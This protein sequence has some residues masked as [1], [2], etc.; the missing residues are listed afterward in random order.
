M[1]NGGT[2]GAAIAAALDSCTDRTPAGGQGEGVEYVSPGMKGQYTDE[3]ILGAEYEVL[4]D[5]KLGINYIHRSLPQVIEDISTDGGTN[6]LITNPG[7]DFASAS[8]DLAKQSA[9]ELMASG[10]TSLT[11]TGTN[12]NADKQALAALYQSRSDQLKSVGKFDKPSRNYD[13][14]AISATQR[15]TKRS[16]VIA[17]YTYSIEKG[18]YPGLFSTETGQLDPNLT[19][20]YDLPDLMANRY[21][22]LG[23]DRPHNLKIDGFYQF[24]LKDLGLLTAGGSVRA[25][26][27]IAHNVLGA[28]PHPGYGTGE[29][30]LLPRGVQDRSPLTSQFDVH[31]SYGRRLNKTVTIEAFANIFNLFDQQEQLN[32]DESYTFDGVNPVVGG[33]LN[34]LKH[35]KTLDISTQT[36]RE[37]NLTPV[38]NK[39]YG[40]T[41][42]SNGGP[43]LQ[44][45]RNIQF[46]MR[47]TF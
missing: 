22:K 43:A 20:L 38:P 23:L 24:D 21:G 32:T 35:A 36:G 28:S 16:L 18:N 45:P 47:L 39:N 40:H 46:G 34:D 1:A 37:S 26:S 7:D 2:D 3:F 42:S 12:C 19:S 44:T 31:L 13:A 9:T 4:S 17:S 33:D 25:Q 10:C 29:S 8:A 15:P 30:Y 5:L 14:V 27:G 41:G 6:Y 11:D